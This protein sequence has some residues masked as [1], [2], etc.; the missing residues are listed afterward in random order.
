MRYLMLAAA[1]AVTIYM[2]FFDD[3]PKRK[4][5]PEPARKETEAMAN[6][7]VPAADTA[8]TTVADHS[9]AAHVEHI[10]N[11]PSRLLPEDGLPHWPLSELLYDLREVYDLVQ[12][13]ERGDSIDTAR[14]IALERKLEALTNSS[15]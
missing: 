2:L 10:V 12:R 13:Y 3:G 11:R 9:P 5:L 8:M 4:L 15:K 7:T 14:V 1:A 6:D